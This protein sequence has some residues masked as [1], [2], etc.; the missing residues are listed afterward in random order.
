MHHLLKLR[1]QNLLKWDELDNITIELDTKPYLDFSNFGLDPSMLENVNKITQA[2]GDLGAKKR[3]RM[4]IS[5]ARQALMNE[6]KDNL[7]SDQS[8]IATAIE[9]VEQKGIVFIDE[10]DKIAESATRQ[11]DKGRVSREGVQRD[12][13][14]LVEGTIVNTK[15]GS[16]HTNHILFIASGAFHISEVSDLIPELRGRFPAVIN[17]QSLGIPEFIQILKNLDNN[18]IRQA[19]ALLSVDGISISFTDNAIS[20]IAKIAFEKNAIEEN[21][22]ARRL[23]QLIEIIISDISFN[24]DIQ[25]ITFDAPDI[26]KIFCSDVQHDF[27]ENLL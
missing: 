8:D 16:I 21:L 6:A 3:K 25:N 18:L 27:S 2:F 12:L 13:L 24:L 22:G 11:G 23:H 10:I 1:Q 20:E 17:M 14:P 5:E 4:L 26:H 7:S 15:Y 9:A 19:Q